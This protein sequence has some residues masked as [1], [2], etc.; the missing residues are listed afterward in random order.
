MDISSNK[1]GDSGLI[2]IGKSLLENVSLRK[3]EI[4]NN[5]FEQNSIKVFLELYNKKGTKDEI[6]YLK[7]EELIEFDI[8]PYKID[9]TFY[10]A[11]VTKD[12]KENGLIEQ[13]ILED[14]PKVIL[15]I[16]D[17]YEN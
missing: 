10:I 2:E 7:K 3:I 17:K 15:N 8:I 5:L 14:D 12:A 9:N 13:T 16:I 4:I 1:I 11:R 6:S